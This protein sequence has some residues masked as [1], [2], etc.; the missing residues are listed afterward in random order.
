MFDPKTVATNRQLV[1]DP[2]VCEARTKCDLVHLCLALFVDEV[3]GVG[4]HC[5]LV[6]VQ[7]PRPE[8]RIVVE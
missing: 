7:P 1:D 3:S 8:C 6:P 4:E 5:V 2:Q